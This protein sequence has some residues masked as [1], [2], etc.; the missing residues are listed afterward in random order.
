MLIRHLGGEK[1]G[2]KIIPKTK[3]VTTLENQNKAEKLGARFPSSLTAQGNKRL[4]QINKRER[5]KS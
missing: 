5:K 2:Q 1:R 3:K 4:N